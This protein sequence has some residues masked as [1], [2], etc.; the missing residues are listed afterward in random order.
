MA[1]HVPKK[2]LRK[3]LVRKIL[4]S[5]KIIFENCF[6]QNYFL[7]SGVRQHYVVTLLTP[8]GPGC[9]CTAIRQCFVA[10]LIP[11]QV[12]AAAVRCGPPPPTHPSIPEQR[13]GRE[14]MWSAL[15]PDH[16][17]GGLR[18][19]PP[20]RPG[21]GGERGVSAVRCDP[22]SFTTDQRCE[23]WVRQCGRLI[24]P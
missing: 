19:G 9:G 10:S 20:S 6:L 4:F 23:D 2:Q 12:C 14:T 7:F 17:G 11:G 16:G 15:T 21:A 22:P 5:S 24:N 8:P 18:C 3:S 1:P 13:V